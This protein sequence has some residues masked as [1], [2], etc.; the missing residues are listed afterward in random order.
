MENDKITLLH[1]RTE[2][3][4]T[5]S[6]QNYLRVSEFSDNSGK[7]VALVSY[8]MEDS[9]KIFAPLVIKEVNANQLLVAL[10]QQ[11]YFLRI[12]GRPASDSYATAI[13][14]MLVDKDKFT[15]PVSS[16]DVVSE[17]EFAPI[18]YPNPGTDR[19]QISWPD[20]FSGTMQVL[21]A[22][23]TLVSSHSVRHTTYKE[24][25]SSAWPAG[26]YVIS[27]YDETRQVVYKYKWVKP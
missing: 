13:V 23:G 17:D 26:V 6:I 10:H 27:L 5:T 16:I 15:K 21:N 1:G 3:P 20:E 9:L 12:S 19:I 24:L 14:L 8:R 11:E 25:D 22:Q 4:T 18:V 2:L 7:P